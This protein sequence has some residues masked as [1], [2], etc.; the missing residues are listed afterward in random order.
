MK[1]SAALHQLLYPERSDRDRVSA[2]SCDATFRRLFCSRDERSETAFP[3]LDSQSSCL[4][5]GTQSY[6]LARGRKKSGVHSASSYTEQVVLFIL[7]NNSFIFDS[8]EEARIRITGINVVSLTGLHTSIVGTYVY[9]SC[10][11]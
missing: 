8:M 9:T 2:I 6:C 4:Y 1:E 5:C 10:V 7:R 11:Y 3:R